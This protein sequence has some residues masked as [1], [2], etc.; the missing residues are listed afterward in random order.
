[1]TTI[2]ES[3]LYLEATLTILMFAAKHYSIAQLFSGS[4][5]PYVA[6]SKLC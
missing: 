4:C 3:S 5:E 1:M 6:Y 2:A